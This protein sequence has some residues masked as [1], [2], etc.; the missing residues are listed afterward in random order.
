MLEE[1]AGRSAIRSGRSIARFLGIC[2]GNS[3]PDSDLAACRTYCRQTRYGENLATAVQ[4]IAEYC[5]KPH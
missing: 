3:W 2:N 5:C 4:K 1:R